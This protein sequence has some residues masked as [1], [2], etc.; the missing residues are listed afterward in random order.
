MQALLHVILFLTNRSC[1]FLRGAIGNAPTINATSNPTK[2]KGERVYQP[3]VAPSLQPYY[4]GTDW[5][6][7]VHPDLPP[8]EIYFQPIYWN[9]SQKSIFDKKHGPTR[10][11]NFE[12]VVLDEMVKLVFHLTALR[13]AE[14][15]EL[16]GQSTLDILRH[17]CLPKVTEEF[18]DVMMVLWERLETFTV[19]IKNPSTLPMS[20]ESFCEY[21]RRVVQD[22]YTETVKDDEDASDNEI[23]NLPQV[24]DDHRDPLFKLRFKNHF[25]KLDDVGNQETFDK[26]LISNQIQKSK[27]FI[28]LNIA[29]RHFFKTCFNSEEIRG[30]SFLKKM[31]QSSSAG[32]KISG[33]NLITNMFW[34][35][36]NLESFFSTS[37]RDDITFDINMA[38]Y[39]VPTIE[40]D[41]FSEV[42]DEL[43][44]DEFFSSNSTTRES[45]LVDRIKVFMYSSV[46][47]LHGK[48][49]PAPPPFDPITPVMSNLNK[50]AL[51]RNVCVGPDGSEYL[52]RMIFN[53]NGSFRRD[54]RGAIDFGEKLGNIFL[55]LPEDT[56]RRNDFR[57]FFPFL[58]DRSKLHPD[59]LYNR[60]ESLLQHL[61][62]I[63]KEK[64]YLDDVGVI[65]GGTYKQYIHIDYVGKKGDKTRKRD[66]E[67]AMNGPNSPASILIGLGRLDGSNGP[68]LAIQAKDVDN[69]QLENDK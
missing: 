58:M 5:P 26:S 19:P 30:H 2:A 25:W 21:F 60:I 44:R 27:C 11:F 67:S 62:L 47:T 51:V 46:Q 33:H 64:E 16:N 40:Y 56:H 4:E 39:H 55:D 65:S 34:S 29:V 37:W 42:Q 14:H 48:I 8:A 36:A 43:I 41:W 12:C 24:K 10:E 63:D 28:L 9:A 54:L 53:Y 68:R 35:A 57:L 31:V 52:Q 18:Y 7:R 50:R 49:K 17:P 13:Y 1:T 22:E 20:E 45:D 38:A 15:F 6:S 59:S 61:G 3:V 66:Y 23:D 69:V 32:K